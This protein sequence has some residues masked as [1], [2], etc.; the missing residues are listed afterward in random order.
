MTPATLQA[1]RRLLFY[2]QPE[3]AK[4]VGGVSDRSWQFWERG[5]RPIPQDVIGRVNS[6]CAW[7]NQTLSEAEAQ[8]KVVGAKNPA[9]VWYDSLDDWIVLNE[10]EPMFWRPHCSVIAEL[11][12][13]HSGKAVVFEPD[14]YCWWLGDRKDSAAMR[15]AWAD[16]MVA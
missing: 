7:R 4:L 3:A 11:C 5:K 9:F 16:G 10:G 2:S 15:A 13:R 14:S 6:L 8:I 1:L 12:A